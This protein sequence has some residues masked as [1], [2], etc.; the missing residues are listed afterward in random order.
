MHHAGRR[1]TATASAAGSARRRDSI[2]PATLH[3][4]GN[5]M[6]GRPAAIGERQ[7]MTVVRET[8]AAV[9]RREVKVV[10]GL[11]RGPVSVASPADAAVRPTGGPALVW[12]VQAPSS[13]AGIVAIVTIETARRLAGDLRLA[14]ASPGAAG[15]KLMARA[16][17]SVAVGRPIAVA[18]RTAVN[19]TDRPGHAAAALTLRD[20]APPAPSGAAA[21][22]GAAAVNQLVSIAAVRFGVGDTLRPGPGPVMLAGAVMVGRAGTSAALRR[23]PASG[24]STIRAAG[25]PSA[26]ARHETAR[27]DR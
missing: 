5:R 8:G 19:G 21:H 7:A 12:L 6:T 23:V 3:A 26:S 10:S 27:D 20:Q 2:A 18:G 16:R 11:A 24:G 1:A 4:R 14:V 15:I 25:A 17:V 9:H 22:G 13:A